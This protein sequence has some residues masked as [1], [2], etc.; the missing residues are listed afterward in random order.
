MVVSVLIPALP[1]RGYTITE[2]RGARN[3]QTGCPASP[4]AGYEVTLR[5]NRRDDMLQILP[6]ERFVQAAVDGDHLAGG[7]AEALRD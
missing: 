2:L 5:G 6:E 7:F 1:A 4:G 3:L